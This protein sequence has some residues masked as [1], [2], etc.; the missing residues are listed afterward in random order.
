MK[1]A[2]TLI[3]SPFILIEQFVVIAAITVFATLVFPVLGAKPD[4]AGYEG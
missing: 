3:S 2:L 1:R 4:G